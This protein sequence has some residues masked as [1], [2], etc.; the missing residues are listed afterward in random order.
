MHLSASTS[1]T[2]PTSCTWLAPVG[3]HDTHG[4]SSQWLQ[5][6]ERISIWSVGN[7]PFT[8][9]AIQSRLKPSGTPF[10]VLQATT[11]SMQPTQRTVSMTMPNL[12]MRHLRLDRDEV[13]V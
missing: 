1:T 11:Q 12:A 13:D 10:S 6:S 7:V 4:G 3:Q 5:R 9:Y 2:P 8:S